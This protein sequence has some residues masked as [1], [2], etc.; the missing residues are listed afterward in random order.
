MFVRKA[1]SDAIRNGHIQSL[2]AYWSENPLHFLR[3]DGFSSSFYS[4]G[5][6]DYTSNIELSYWNLLRQVGVFPFLA[7]IIML[8][9]PLWPII[10]KKENVMM[11]IGYVAYLIVAY[12]NPLLYSSTG[13]TVILFIYVLCGK[14]APPSPEKRLSYMID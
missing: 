5:I 6:G 14:E 11:L 3:G 9:Y 12:T 10:R 7:T 13:L 4:S 2:L 1:G 8:V